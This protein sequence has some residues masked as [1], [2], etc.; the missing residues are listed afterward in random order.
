MDQWVFIEHM[1]INILIRTY[2]AREMDTRSGTGAPLDPPIR[3]VF[4]GMHKLLPA[5][6]AALKQ[7]NIDIV[8]IVE[9]L[10]TDPRELRQLLRDLRNQADAVV[11]FALPL[12]LLLEIKNANFKVFVFRMNSSIVSNV[13]EAEA[14]VAQDPE[15]RTYLFGRPG[16]PIRVL[17]FV[18]VDEITEIRTKQVWPIIDPPPIKPPPS[19]S[20]ISK[21]YSKF[22]EILNLLLSLF[23]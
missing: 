1:V 13:T 9:N 10:P 11:T 2:G 3:A 5:Q 12:D 17:E 21:I 22:L 15:W 7:L 18:A 23:K 19:A 16:E 4:V 8:K 6:D 20:R 14:F